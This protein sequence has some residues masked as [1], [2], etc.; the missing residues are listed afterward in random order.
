MNWPILINLVLYFAILM[1]IGLRFCRK[2]ETLGGYLLGD[3]GLG[4]WVTVK[5]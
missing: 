3:R 1:V 2:E 4:A 5:S